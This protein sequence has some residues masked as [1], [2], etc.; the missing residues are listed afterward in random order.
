VAFDTA[1]LML[2]VG[3]FQGVIDLGGG[4]LPSVGG[5]DVW[6]ARFDPLGEH[7]WSARYGEADDQVGVDVSSDETDGV[8]LTGYFENS[9]NFGGD[10][11]TSADDEDIFVASL[12]LSGVHRWSTRLGSLGPDRA[13]SVCVNGGGLDVMVAGNFRTLIDFGAGH[14]FASSGSNDAFVAKFT[15]A[16]NFRWAHAFG[17]VDDDAAMGVA[18][19]EDSEVVVAGYFE[20]EIDRGVDVLASAGGRDMFLGVYAP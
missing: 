9:I 10:V 20:G 11:L 17:D 5:Y 1:D 13:Q 4:T 6:A 2:V 12:S 7:I 18:T 16:G 8:V 3:S 14:A 19:N 15:Q